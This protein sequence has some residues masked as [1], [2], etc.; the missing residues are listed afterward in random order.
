MPG[1]EG[2]VVER[3]KAG[4][5]FL[6]VL[7]G[8]SRVVR[9]R[10]EKEA[11]V[12]HVDVEVITSV[13]I[14]KGPVRSPTVG[15]IIV[16]CSEPMKA[17]KERSKKK[18]KKIKPCSNRQGFNRRLSRIKLVPN[19]N[20]LLATIETEVVDGRRT[21]GTGLRAE[22]ERKKEQ[23]IFQGKKSSLTRS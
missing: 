23:I 4:C 13:V 7:V 21:R 15:E 1:L 17:D 14:E 11:R 3:R 5:I 18:K 20:V 19:R 16:G 12:R 2:C 6:N 22:E 10:E 9:E 8:Q